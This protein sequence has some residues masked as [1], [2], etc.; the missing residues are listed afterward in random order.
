MKVSVWY[1]PE[2]DV[3]NIRIKIKLY[4]S[5]KFV[6]SYD[7]QIYSYGILFMTNKAL[8]NALNNDVNYLNTIF[9]VS[10]NI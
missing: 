7:F 1:E 3:Q 2:I 10:F 8:V 5:L 6:G 9:Q 4:D